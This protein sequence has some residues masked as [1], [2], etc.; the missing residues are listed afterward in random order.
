M[1]NARG[2]LTTSL[3]D[4]AASLGLGH[5]TA[6]NAPVVRTLE[7]LVHFGLARWQDNATLTCRS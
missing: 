3:E 6:P 2:E 4:F 7:R 1:A 5:G